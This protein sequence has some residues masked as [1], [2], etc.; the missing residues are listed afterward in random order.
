MPISPWNWRKSL[1]GPY[2]Y[3]LKT[4]AQVKSRAV[5]AGRAA[6]DRYVILYD[7]ISRNT[8]PR[9]DP[10]MSGEMFNFNTGA[11]YFLWIKVV[12]Y[13]VVCWM[14]T[15]MT[16]NMCNELESFPWTWKIQIFSTWLTMYVAQLWLSLLLENNLFL[17]TQ[18]S[19]QLFLRFSRNSFRS[20]LSG[21]DSQSHRTDL[22]FR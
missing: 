12:V 5:A 13:Y 18:S 22:P 8:P 14:N 19:L 6:Y 17:L 16:N 1:S 4:I 7:N 11:L 10:E 15:R 9:I 3:L 2:F 20:L 21:P